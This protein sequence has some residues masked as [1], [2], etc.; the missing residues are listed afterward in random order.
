M[1]KKLSELTAF[2]ADMIARYGDLPV[3]TFDGG[4]IGFSVVPSA[5]GVRVEAGR[6]TEIVID[7]LV[8]Q[9]SA[10]D[11]ASAPITPERAAKKGGIPPEVIAVWNKLIEA[12]FVPSRP[13]FSISQN[14][15][16]IALLPLL[17][18]AGHRQTLFDR[19]WLDIEGHFQNAGWD[20]AYDGGDRGDNTEPVFRFRPAAN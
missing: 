17:G 5:D 16:V 7:L 11:K 3:Y 10:G 1:A 13:H 19:G 15:A 4:V 6:A 9:S 20:V 14:D 12:R 2:F 8:A 18:D